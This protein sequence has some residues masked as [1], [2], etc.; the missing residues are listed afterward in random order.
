MG[1]GPVSVRDMGTAEG[2]LQVNVPVALLVGAIYRIE[3]DEL[4]AL[5]TGHGRSRMRLGKGVGLLLVLL[6]RSLLLLSLFRLRRLVAHGPPLGV[7]VVG[8]A[9]NR[10]ALYHPRNVK[11][12]RVGPRQSA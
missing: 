7:R 6:R 2:A 9:R 1:T 5:L 10:I 4:L 11:P 8:A 12:R 3:N